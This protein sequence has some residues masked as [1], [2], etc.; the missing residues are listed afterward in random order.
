[1]A[2]KLTMLAV[3]TLG[4]LVLT[5]NAMKLE[6]SSEEVALEAAA[7]EEATLT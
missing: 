4:L 5:S 7:M 1:M 3:A 6:S 2:A